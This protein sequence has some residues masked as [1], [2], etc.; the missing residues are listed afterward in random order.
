MTTA[1]CKSQAGIAKQG[2][3]EKYGTLLKKRSPMNKIWELLEQLKQS[4]E[5]E[6]DHGEQ[7]INP[8]DQGEQICTLEEGVFRSLSPMLRTRFEF[9]SSWHNAVLSQ[10]WL[11]LA[12][13][14]TVRENPIFNEW[15]ALRLENWDFIPPSTVPLR[16]CA[17][18]AINPYEPSETY[19]VWEDDQ[20]EPAIWQFFSADYNYFKSFE[21][22]LEWNLGLRQDDDSGR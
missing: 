13:I 18:F 21:N 8:P 2:L 12:E 15:F 5:N 17:I 22:Y 9:A 11:S 16:N 3:A 20:E 19:L 14:C 7:V 1:N 10:D 4:N 6:P